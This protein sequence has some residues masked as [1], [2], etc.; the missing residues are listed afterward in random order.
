MAYTIGMTHEQRT[1]VEYTKTEMKMPEGSK[2]KRAPDAVPERE[3]GIILWL[4]IGVL[5]L[6]LVGFFLWYLSLEEATP[7]RDSGAARPTAAENQEPE[8]RNAV[9]D[10]DTFNTMST[11]DTLP[12]IEADLESTDLSTL[13]RE[14]TAIEN[15]LSANR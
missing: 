4:L 8:S 5:A 3:F 11:S 9:V 12:A 10:V 13:D 15:A 2:Q 7:D 14:R 1:P 6:L